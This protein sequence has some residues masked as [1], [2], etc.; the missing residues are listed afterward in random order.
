MSVF[1]VFATISLPESALQ[2]RTTRTGAF[3]EQHDGVYLRLYIL[4]C[5][6]P[7]NYQVMPMAAIKRLIP[8]WSPVVN[9]IIG[10]FLTF[11]TD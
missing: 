3:N 5:V 7:V 9:W 11:D 8:W 2:D 6:K 1:A 4:S 10:L